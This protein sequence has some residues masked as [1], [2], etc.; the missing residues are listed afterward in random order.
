MIAEMAIRRARRFARTV[1]VTA[2]LALG[3]VRPADAQEAVTATSGDPATIARI[4]ALFAEI[5]R[6]TPAYRRTTHELRGFSLEGG[7]LVGFYRGS[8]LRKLAARHFGETGQATQEYYFS[9]GRPVFVHVV[10]SRYDEPLSG[11][12]VFR[13]E[14]RYY[15]DGGRLIRHVRAHHPAAEE[16]DD[17]EPLDSSI[18]YL[19]KT[20][21]RFAACAAATGSEPPECTAS[22]HDAGGR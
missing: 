19:L 5:E 7:E 6:E 12:V 20:A 16:E 1:L 9:D 21:E 11:R 4:R 3:V 10:D 17:P 22:D 18:P 14:D 13:T 2:G 15:F 8:E